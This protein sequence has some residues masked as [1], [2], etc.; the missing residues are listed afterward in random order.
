MSKLFRMDSDSRNVFSM[1]KCLLGIILLNTVSCTCPKGTY[2]SFDLEGCL[3]CPHLPELHCAG[4][5]RRDR[6]SCLDNCLQ[7]DTLR[8]EF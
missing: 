1:T 4:V 6:R 2:H 7:G 8:F 3:D 5:H